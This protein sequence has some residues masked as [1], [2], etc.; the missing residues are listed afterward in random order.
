MTLTAQTSTTAIIVSSCD[1]YS[2][3]WEPFF[4][5]LFRY[6]P[7]CPYPIHLISNKQRYPDSRVTMHC[8]EEDR[9]WA[10]N[11][12][13]VLDE[14]DCSHVLYF[15]EDYFLQRA[16]D[17]NQ[18]ARLI[19]F[20]VQHNA[21][22]VRLCGSPDPDVVHDNAFGLGL[23]SP[24]LKF[25]VSLQAA[26]WERET[27]ISLLVPGEN[28]WQME[29]DGSGRSASLPTQFFGCYMNRPVIDYYF[30]TGILKGKWVPGALRLC[31]REGIDVDTS[32]RDIHSE[33]PFVVRQFHNLKLVRTARS[34]L[35]RGRRAA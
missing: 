14:V 29:I 31:R 9:A 17:G 1:A 10:S 8:I 4:T 15:Q 35:R 22:F 21:G 5:L 12:Q 18:I 30:F 27:L 25:R 24:G 13:L 6:W 20:A 3:A 32:R 16:V 2:D 23:L 7:D 19:E 26:I 33:W 11:L 28:G 34:L